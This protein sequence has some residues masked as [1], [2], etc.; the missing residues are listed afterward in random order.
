MESGV[1]AFRWT[2]DIDSW[3]DDGE[4]AGAL[5]ATTL[6]FFFGDIT[7]FNYCSAF[8][9]LLFYV[10]NIKKKKKEEVN[11]LFQYARWCVCVHLKV[12]E[13][14]KHPEEKS[15]TSIKFPI[16]LRDK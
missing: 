13:K 9:V 7:A 11:R 8:L 6:P 5:A 2:E 10:L 16:T 12:R 4:V 3:A 15:K 14:E 1:D